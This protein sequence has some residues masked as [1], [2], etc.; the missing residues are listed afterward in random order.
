[1]TNRRRG[2]DN[3]QFCRVSL[4]DCSTWNH[5]MQASQNRHWWPIVPR[6]T[7][8]LVKGRL[9]KQRLGGELN[10]M[11]HVKHSGRKCGIV[12]TRLANKFQVGQNRRADDFGDSRTRDW[13]GR[14]WRGKLGLFH[15]EHCSSEIHS[16]RV[17]HV[18]HLA[19]NSR[20]CYLASVWSVAWLVLLR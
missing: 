9:Q 7:T 13:I 14:G 20:V 17:F 15:V 8:S 4:A 18:K 12:R 16:F 6:G 11:F 5:S 3:A 10:A 19:S 2:S 1:M